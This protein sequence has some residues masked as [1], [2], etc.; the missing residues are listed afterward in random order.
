MSVNTNIAAGDR[1]AFLALV[2]E[3][4]SAV[5]TDPLLAFLERCIGAPDLRKQVKDSLPALL[6]DIAHF[7]AISHGRHPGI[8]DHAS[9]KISDQE[10]R[11]WMVA[12]IEGF[13]AERGMLNRLMVAAGPIHRHTDQDKVTAIL[14]T[15]ARSFALLATS[16]RAGCAAGAAVA[17]VIDWQMT[18]PLLECT[19]LA[20]GID[21]MPTSLPSTRNS[22]ALIETLS[23]TP[24]IARAINFGSEQMLAQ[25]K[26]LW[27]LVAARHAAMTAR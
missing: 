14:A 10:A 24:A 12:A 20:L 7:M 25:Q 3:R 8:V 16:D 2:E 6:A 18:R 11:D 21:V 19:A 5:V 13:A 27:Q 1:N 23:A 17:F 9:G 22:L 15:Q 4:G 26:G